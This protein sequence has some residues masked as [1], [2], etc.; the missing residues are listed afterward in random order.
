MAVF[1]TA[2][3]PPSVGNTMRLNMGWTQKSSSALTNSV[4][5][6]SGRMPRRVSRPATADSR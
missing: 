5:A 3:E 6:N 4:I 1:Q 2:G